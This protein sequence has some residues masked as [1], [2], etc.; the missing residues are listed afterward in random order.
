MLHELSNAL[1]PPQREAIKLDTTF[2]IADEELLD[3]EPH[4]FLHVLLRYKHKEVKDTAE[5]C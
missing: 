2:A 5:K 1:N 3:K 4:K